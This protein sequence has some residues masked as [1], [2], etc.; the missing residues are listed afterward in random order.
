M[1][2]VRKC[3]ACYA[4]M[5]GRQCVCGYQAASVRDY[6]LALPSCTV[7]NHRYIVLRVLGA[8][9]FGVTY[10]AKDMKR[11]SYCAVKEYVPVGIAVRDTT[12]RL[13]PENQGKRSIYRHGMQRFLEEAYILQKLRSFP[14]I[15]TI[16]DCFE[17]NGTAYFAMEYVYG[18]TVKAQV[19]RSG[20]LQWKDALR[21]IG[22]VS[23]TLDRIHKTCGVFHRDI[24]P[25][26]IMLS[27][28]GTVKL[29]DFGSAKFISRETCQ[30]FTVVLKDGYAPPEQYSSS[31]PQGPY[32]DVYALAS[33][34]YYMVTGNKIPSA[35]ARVAGTT[36]VP[37]SSLVDVPPYISEAID[38][39]LCL[40]RKARTQNCEVFLREMNLLPP[41]I[42]PQP[43]PFVQKISG[44]S[45]RAAC[46]QILY[47]G[48]SHTEQI[49][50]EQ[51][52]RV[53]RGEHCD[54]CLPHDPHLS[55][56]HFYLFYSQ[57]RCLFAVKDISRN[58]IWVGNKKLPKNQFVIFRQEV[59][60]TMP[61]GAYMLVLSW[62][63]SSV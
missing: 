49:V 57:K 37:L 12:G 11:G 4:D 20:K 9:G 1:S 21:I 5:A 22:T 28:D 36:Y 51:F 25:E 7:L 54:I 18:T 52:Y 2:L 32:T 59:Q 13:Q 62:P 53:G 48:T 6:A 35:M 26:N 43:D 55:K 63:P 27:K 39:A 44:T 58:G 15:V 19:V 23:G 47:C 16:F 10:E 41:S 60:L 31:T 29:L 42:P 30:N 33:T 61:G 46:L 38:H 17:E 45:T 34:F 50:P 14:T 56:I 24:S 40:S 3:P 8:G